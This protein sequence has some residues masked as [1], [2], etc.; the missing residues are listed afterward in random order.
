V[1]GSR[2]SKTVAVLTGTLLQCQ[3]LNSH[4]K[5]LQRRAVPCM[6]PAGT[7]SEQDGLSQRIGA[8]RVPARNGVSIFPAHEKVLRRA[9]GSLADPVTMKKRKRLEDCKGPYGKLISYRM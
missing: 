5:R 4:V 2:D 7:N 3:F 1:G 8:P 9:D 6:P